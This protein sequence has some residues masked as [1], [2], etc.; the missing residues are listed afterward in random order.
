MSKKYLGKM[1]KIEM[2]YDEDNWDIKL[3]IRC[4][5]ILKGLLE[6]TDSEYELKKALIK[7]DHALHE[8]FAY[9]EEKLESVDEKK[10]DS[11]IEKLEKK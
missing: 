4:T 8:Y 6:I 11:V 10:V 5:D 1:L 3:D 9:V 7:I 2:L